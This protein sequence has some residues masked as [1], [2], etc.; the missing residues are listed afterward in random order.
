MYG[1]KNLLGKPHVFESFK[2]SH[3]LFYTTGHW[4]NWETLLIPTPYYDEFM[5]MKKIEV[6][7]DESRVLS[8]IFF[9]YLGYNP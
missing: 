7:D 4:S 5:N 3:N 8:E 2:N 1:Y 6:P 9:Y